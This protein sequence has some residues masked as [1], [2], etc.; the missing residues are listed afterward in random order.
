MNE[1]ITIKKNSKE[2]GRELRSAR[3]RRG[4]TQEQAAKIIDAART[5]L[6]AIEKGE[7][8]IKPAELV[9][10]AEAYECRVND[11]LRDRPQIEPMK[12]QFRGPFKPQSKEME[13]IGD[14]VSELEDLARDYLEIERLTNNHAKRHYPPEYRIEGLPVE[15]AAE[16][17]ASRERNRLG[18]GD[19]PVP[20][21]RDVLEHEVG[22]R[23]FYLP[24][25]PSTFS[26]IYLYEDELGGCIAVNSLHP[27]ERRRWSLAHE[28]AHFLVHRYQ[29]RMFMD[30][31]YQRL[32]DRE[33]FA[34]RFAMHFLM[35]SAG[36]TRRFNDL[37][38][39]DGKRSPAKLCILAHYYGVS[40]AALSLRLEGMGLIPTGTWDKLKDR[41]FK[42]RE[43]YRQIG[44]EPVPEK[45]DAT[46]AR[47]RFL[48]IEAFENDKLSEGQLARFLRTDRLEA[49]RIAHDL[50]EHETDVTEEESVQIDLGENSEAAGGE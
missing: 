12:V 48:A 27:E 41:G 44:L 18:L 13:T 40:F 11:L 10:L 33:Q 30:G 6:V 36:L 17:I 2:L 19:G 43:A 4:M 5:T 8:G 23:I 45:S 9:R 42:V 47:Y 1:N 20:V 14:S 3:T 39:T 34:D 26:A 38:G 46:P 29:P 37:V 49:R 50:K 28:Y 25:R 22:L 15:H 31:K 35:P 16:G 21:L 7:R 32:P 24:M